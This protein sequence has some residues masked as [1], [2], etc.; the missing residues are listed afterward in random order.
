LNLTALGEAAKAAIKFIA[1][2]IC[3]HSDALK[4]QTSQ[5]N[6]LSLLSVR[7]EQVDSNNSDG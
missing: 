1:S 6:Y 4:V 3:S 2:H 7:T 5:G